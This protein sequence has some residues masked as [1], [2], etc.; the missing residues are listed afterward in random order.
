MNRSNIYIF[1]NVKKVRFIEDK[2]DKINKNFY[3]DNL[4][5]HNYF[6]NVNIEYDCKENNKSP[7]INSKCDVSTNTDPPDLNDKSTNTKTNLDFF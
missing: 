6:P 2:N 5:N 7:L 3:F 4:K 1:K